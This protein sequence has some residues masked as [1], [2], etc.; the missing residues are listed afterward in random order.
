[1]G[2]AFKNGDAAVF[3]A[4]LADYRASLVP[5]FSPVLQKA[6]AEVFFNQMQPFYAAMIIY[7]IAGLLG[8]CSWFNLSETL[9]RSAVWLVGLAFVIHTTGLIYRMVLEG[10]PPV[11]N[12]YSSAIFIGWGAVVLG[13]ILE[14]NPP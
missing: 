9:R 3:N 8:V 1:M 2:D 4:A 6:R 10:R 11:T 7:I 12:L 14:K 5:N 13:L